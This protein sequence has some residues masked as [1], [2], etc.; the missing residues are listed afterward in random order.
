MLV[1]MESMLVLALVLLVIFLGLFIFSWFKN[2]NYNVFRTYMLTKQRI[3]WNLII[4]SNLQ[5]YLKMAFSTA[6]SL[7]LMKWDHFGQIF[8]SLLA[9]LT[10]IILLV[11]PVVY[12]LV[13]RRNRDFLLVPSIRDRIGSLYLGLR[14][15]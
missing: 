13:L 9:I 6:T 14:E 8:T 15:E 5:S 4:R 12:L 7:Q 3:L 10:G 2:H 1:S 11:L